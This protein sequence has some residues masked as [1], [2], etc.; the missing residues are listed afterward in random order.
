MCSS[1]LENKKISFQRDERDISNGGIPDTLTYAYRFNLDWRLLNDKSR[2]IQLNLGWKLGF[3]KNYYEYSLNYVVKDNVSINNLQGFNAECG[4]DLNGS[5]YFMLSV[6]DFNNN[7]GETIIA[8]Y[9]ESLFTDTNVIAH[10]PRS[11]E[12]IIKFIS[13]HYIHEYSRKYFGPVDITRLHIRLLD[14]FGRIV[15]LNNNDF[16][17]SLVINQAYNHEHGKD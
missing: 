13:G 14:E 9:Q 3:R 12:S 5:K 2:P 10:I 4:I 11:D 1:D 16:S 17:F 8:P 15:D 6:N 7:T